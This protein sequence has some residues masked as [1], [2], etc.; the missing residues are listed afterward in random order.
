MLF[1]RD[2]MKQ[3]SRGR[4]TLLGDACHPTLPF[5]AQGAAMAIEDAAVLS[6]CLATA[7]SVEAGLQRYGSLRVRRTARIQMG[8]RRNAKVYH[9]SGAQAWLRNRAINWGA[10]S[11]M[12]GLFR[13]DALSVR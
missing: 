11:V 12:A 2:P 10:R 7:G 5:M 4:I 9:M 13:Y 8:S 1:D 3:W 6:R